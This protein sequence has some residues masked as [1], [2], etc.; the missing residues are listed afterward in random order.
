MLDTKQMIQDGF[1]KVQVAVLVNR[2]RNG[3]E[4]L[5]IVDSL[6]H[7]KM[8]KSSGDEVRLTTMLIKL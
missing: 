8:Y 3:K 4:H 6:E 7:A 5:I 2:D 1:K